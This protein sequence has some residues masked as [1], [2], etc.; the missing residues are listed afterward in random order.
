MGR[1]PRAL[2][3]GVAGFAGSHLADLLVGRGDVD[4]HGVMRPDD[5]TQHLAHLGER[6]HLHRVDLR[7][8]ERVSEALRTIKPDMLFHLAAQASVGQSWERP[9]DTLIGNI[10]M[11]LNLLQAIVAQGL[12]PRI[13]VVGSADEYGR[14]TDAD[15]PID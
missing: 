6:I 11:Q 1:R 7:D 9:A 8:D 14:V 10:T 2:I 15:L 12:A 4:V 3:T 13:L 5:G